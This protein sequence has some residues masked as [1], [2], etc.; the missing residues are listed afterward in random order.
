LVEDGFKESRS[1]LEF[2]WRLWLMLLDLP[3]R[4]FQP[5]LQRHR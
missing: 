2:T 4:Y 3:Q 1:T 5:G